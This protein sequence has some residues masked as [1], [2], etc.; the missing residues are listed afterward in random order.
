MNK[1]R[2]IENYIV[3]IDKPFCIRE[4]SLITGIAYS[5]VSNNVSKF[6]EQGKIIIINGSKTPRFYRYIRNS[7]AS[8]KAEPLSFTPQINKLKIIYDK[9]SIFHR[10][11]D[12]VNSLS[13]S[14]S[15]VWRYVKILLHDDCIEKHRGRY[16]QRELKLSGRSFDEYPRINKHFK[17]PA[18]ISDLE[19]ICN[20]GNFEIPNTNNMTNA[21]IIKLS[22]RSQIQATILLINRRERGN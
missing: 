2:L 14:E 1:R 17:R 16:Y 9:I 4:I 13:F 6:K 18:L 20:K 3:Q 10:V 11:A 22:E 5:T 12:V 15:T 19:Q 7:K 21:E 8:Q